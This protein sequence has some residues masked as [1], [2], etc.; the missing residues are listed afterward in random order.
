[1]VDYKRNSCDKNF[2]LQ[3]FQNNIIIS[4]EFI[5]M[6]RFICSY[7]SSIIIM[8]Y[9][10]YDYRIYFNCQRE[11]SNQ[12]KSAFTIMNWC[13][14]INAKRRNTRNENENVPHMQM[15]WI[16]NGNYYW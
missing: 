3:R 15:T 4:S 9:V 2:F 10:L 1:M 6:F 16:N 5:Y 14:V 13:Y 7:F 8:T 12:M 11:N